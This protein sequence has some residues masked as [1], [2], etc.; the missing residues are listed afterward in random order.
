[1]RGQEAEGVPQAYWW[2]VCINNLT[3]HHLL[4]PGAIRM[5]QKYRSYYAVICPLFI[6]IGV[7]IAICGVYPILAGIGTIRWPTA[8][9]KIISSEMSGP[10]ETTEGTKYVT[11]IWY[12]YSVNGEAYLEPILIGLLF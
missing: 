3:G 12:Q 6:L 9:G 4:I 7:I 8:P 11:K 1:M 10:Y 2:S 5:T